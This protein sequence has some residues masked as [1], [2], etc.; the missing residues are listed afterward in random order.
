MCQSGVRPP[1][2]KLRQARRAFAFA[3]YD[4]AIALIAQEFSGRLPAGVDRYNPRGKLEP[5]RFNMKTLIVSLLLP[6]SIAAA[7]QGPVS[8]WNFNAGVADTC[9]KSKDT[10]TARGGKLRFV[11]AKELP[12]TTGKAVAIGVRRG[13]ARSLTLA[14]SDDVK[15]GASYTI[16]AWIH[17]TEIGAAWNRLVLNWGRGKAYHF[18][19][20]GG[21][22]S[23]YH[24]QANGTE[25]IAEGGRVRKN[26]WNHVVGVA[27]RNSTKPVGSRVEVYLNGKLVASA[28]F[29]GTI[30]TL[31][32]E[33]L[34]V[35]DS[36]GGSGADA[37]YRG[38]IDD[39]AI[40]N[41]ALSPAEISKRCTARKKILALPSSEIAG[42]LN[43]LKND[44][45][46]ETAITLE[47]NARQGKLS[48]GLCVI[49]AK[50]LDSK[51]IFVRA[52][53]EWAITRRVGFDNNHEE[54]KWTS[55]S[56]EP[57]F[58]KWMEIPL[59]EQI[60]MDYCRQAV[61]LGIYNDSKKLKTSLDEM[62]ARAGKMGA[63]SDSLKLLRARADKVSDIAALRGLWLDARRAMRP[64][65]FA[66]AEMDFD[67]LILYK[68]FACHYKPNVCGVHTSWSYK[69]G[70]DVV[71]V[72]GLDKHKSI[73]TLI[74]RDF[75]DSIAPA[76]IA[77]L[78]R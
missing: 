12:G 24:A 20:H 49:A 71:I 76:T 29:D 5:E 54:V 6:L 73:K 33:G 32:N 51:D 52:L 21:R 58:K 19:I 56:N 61:D 35:G 78:S 28:A 50:L 8:T 40:W 14:A 18:A 39:L 9:G 68:R 7:E 25:R 55:A 36:A 30:N 42:L 66:R 10:L 4:A 27:R 77:G 22:V 34:G 47:K 31:K 59:A 17:P 48:D 16:E 2:S 1:H 26:R 46:L 11:T 57:W 72:S 75:P 64:L 44:P 60:E 67:E 41:R 53:A 65:A 45:P 62:I 15:L 3:L 38:Y 69:P 63:K 37:R 43:L 74:N 70:G 13:D 23:L